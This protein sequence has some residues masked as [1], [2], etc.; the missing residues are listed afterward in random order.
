MDTRL[1]ITPMLMQR[2]PL[3]LFATKRTL[4]QAHNLIVAARDT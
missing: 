4:E 1:L 3:K 2:T